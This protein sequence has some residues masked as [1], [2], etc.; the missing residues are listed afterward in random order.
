MAE[1]LCEEFCFTTRQHLI[2]VLEETKHTLDVET[3]IGA[4][5]K[6]IEVENELSERFS[7]RSLEGES[8]ESKPEEE[9]DEEEA[10]PELLNS[11]SAEA[12]KEKYRRF[13][14]QQEKAKKRQTTEVATKPQTVQ[15][16]KGMVSS[17]FDLYMDLYIKKEDAYELSSGNLTLYRSMKQMLDKAMASE[18]WIVDD[19]DRLKVCNSEVVL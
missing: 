5:K 4:L 6:T 12:V 7:A 2:D 17:A 9:E 1:L 13:Q 8:V 11:F 16:F 10:S 15:K 19:D 3:L 14:R 18:M